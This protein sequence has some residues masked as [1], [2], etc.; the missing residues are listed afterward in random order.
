M[1]SDLHKR[2]ETRAHQLWEA[3]GRPEGESERYWLEAE[4]ALEGEMHSGGGIPVTDELE[5]V[6]EPAAP[7]GARSAKK[8]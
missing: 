1:T 6:S 3:A 5:P 4:A 2:I 8:K 7:K